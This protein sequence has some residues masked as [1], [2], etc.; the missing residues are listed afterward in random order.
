MPGVERIRL[1]V[2]VYWCPTCYNA[3][4]VVGYAID[5]VPSVH[6]AAIIGDVNNTHPYILMVSPSSSLNHT[7]NKSAETG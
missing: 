6:T 2:H 1:C 7:H 4:I 3:K 5:S